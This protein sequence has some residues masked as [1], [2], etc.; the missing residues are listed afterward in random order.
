MI[1]AGI[2]LRISSLVVAF[3]VLFLFLSLTVTIFLGNYVT[4]LDS[5]KAQE[6]YHCST[7]VTWNL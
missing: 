2:F 7:H 1:I 4:Y 6:Y 3:F 5:T